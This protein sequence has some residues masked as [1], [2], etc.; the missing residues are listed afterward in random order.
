MSVLAIDK[1][2]DPVPWTRCSSWWVVAPKDAVREWFAGH[3]PDDT[4][5]K[6]FAPPDHVID[7]DALVFAVVVDPD[8]AKLCTDLLPRQ[9][10]EPGPAG[11]RLVDGRL[12]ADTCPVQPAC[13]RSRLG[14]VGHCSSTARLQLSV[15]QD[16]LPFAW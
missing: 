12:A 13:Q 4:F 3:Q 10:L 2:H 5:A 8:L 15:R 1:H 6:V 7:G 9:A 16:L 11:E 14:D